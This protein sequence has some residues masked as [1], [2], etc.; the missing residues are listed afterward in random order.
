MSDTILIAAMGT[1][2]VA[3]VGVVWGLMRGEIAELKGRVISAEREVSQLKAD[4][5]R[6]DERDKVFEKGIE[7][8]TRA[9]DEFDTR[10]GAQIERLSRIVEGQV[11]RYTPPGGY[12]YSDIP[13]KEGGDE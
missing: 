11:R 4:N 7:R 10:I 8:L 12:K 2:I 3:V 1:V 5:A 13:K 6:S 9:I